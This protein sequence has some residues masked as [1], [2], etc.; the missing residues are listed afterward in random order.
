MNANNLN[1]TYIRSFFTFGGPLDI[2]GTRFT[3]RTDR[4]LE[5]DKFVNTFVRKIIANIDK[6]LPKK[7]DDSFEFG[8]KPI[9]FNFI[10]MQDDFYLLSLED[11]NFSGLSIMFVFGYLTYHLGSCFLSYI[12]VVLILLS[13]P[14]SVLITE[15]IL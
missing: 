2:N 15:G 9:I 10:V 1:V 11:T 4:P 6:A 5:Q 12:G 3:D 8:M 14:L 7:S 13:F